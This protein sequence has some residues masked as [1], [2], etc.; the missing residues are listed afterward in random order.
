LKKEDFDFKSVI[1]EY[2]VKKEKEKKKK[3]REI[4]T[5]DYRYNNKR[6]SI[7]RNQKRKAQISDE[8]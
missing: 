5:Q 4:H 3:R 2:F 1:N 7:I 8:K 6:N